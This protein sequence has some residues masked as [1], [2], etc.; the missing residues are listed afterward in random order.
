MHLGNSKAKNYILLRH[1]GANA[2][3]RGLSHALPT[4]LFLLLIAL[5]L[6]AREFLPD[7]VPAV[8]LRVID[9]DSLVVRATI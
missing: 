9:G 4:I 5:P 6:S 2:L 8:V 3:R 1:R 7:P